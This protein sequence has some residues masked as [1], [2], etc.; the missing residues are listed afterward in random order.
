MNTEEKT[1]RSNKKHKKII[2]VVILVLTVAVLADFIWSNTYIEV[3]KLSGSFKD[4]PESF[5]GCKIIHISDF[6]NE[7]GLDYYE[8]LADKVNDCEPDYIFVTG[9]SV[10]SLFPEVD[11]SLKLMER[12]TDI[13]PVYLVLG[14]HEYALSE[15]DR[16][17]F[18]SGAKECGVNVL[19]N[20][21]V[22]VTRGTDSISIV[23]LDNTVNDAEV[24]AQA[25]EDF[26]ILL[27]HYPEDCNYFNVSAEYAGTHID[28][29]F[30]G[31]AHG[32]LIKLPFV[33]GLYAPGQGLFPQYVDGAYDI[34]GTTLVVSRGTGNSGVTQRFSDP[35]E[36]IEYTL[37]K[38]K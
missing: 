25:K 10:D 29:D 31:H 7:W 9:D 12:L 26:V 21:C 32:G 34:G 14:N 33:N 37:E 35:F 27:N 38:D 4:L 11:R 15:E 6:H 17:A 23:G 24:L 36:I 13:C 22:T 19:T 5:D 8:R 3:K 18:V 1:S 20:E 30:T 28:I 2:F 16:T